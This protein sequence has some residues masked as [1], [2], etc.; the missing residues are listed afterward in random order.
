MK[1]LNQTCNDK[2]MLEKDLIIRLFLFTSVLLLTISIISVARIWFL[3]LTDNLKQN[4]LNTGNYL[5]WPLHNYYRGDNLITPALQLQ[6]VSLVIQVTS[7][8]LRRNRRIMWFV[9]F[10]VFMIL[11]TTDMPF[12]LID[13]LHY[14][15]N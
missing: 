5:P 15:P 14:D 12:W 7:L 6:S 3:V 9:L 2:G 13:Y 10:T 1:L 8:L 11:V 4:I